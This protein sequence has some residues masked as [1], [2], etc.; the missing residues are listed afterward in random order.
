VKIYF[1]FDSD[2]QVRSIAIICYLL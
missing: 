1:F 2:R